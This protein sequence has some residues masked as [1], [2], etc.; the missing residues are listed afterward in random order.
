M[1]I[2]DY[3]VWTRKLWSATPQ[4]T[5]DYDSLHASLGLVT[6]ASEL[7][8]VYKKNLFYGRAF[9]SS[10]IL[11]ESGDIIYYLARILDANGYTL[12]QA[13]EANI[14]KLTARFGDAFD[15]DK[16]NNRD[17]VKEDKAVQ[18][19]SAQAS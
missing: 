11:D 5:V 1:Q 18:S 6:E 3:Q 14:A 17:T 8:D 19:Y 2:N 10:K 16:A 7:A 15:A 13:V 12:E 9:S 4:V